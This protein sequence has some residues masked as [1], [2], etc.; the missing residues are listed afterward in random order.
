MRRHFELHALLDMHNRTDTSL[1]TG[2]ALSLVHG[3][4]GGGSNN[5]V[6]KSNP[7]KDLNH[8]LGECIV[9]SGDLGDGAEGVVLA[10]NSDKVSHHVSDE[11][12]HCRAA[13][14]ELGFTEISHEWLVSLG[15]IQ[16][17]T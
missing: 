9:G 1:T 16:L 8:G 13:V 10:R 15:K 12:Q 14:T 3:C 2:F 4:N 5:N 11:S 6:E 17:Y 7:S